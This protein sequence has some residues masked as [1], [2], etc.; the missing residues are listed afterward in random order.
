M[1]RHY[2]SYDYP[3]VYFISDKHAQALKKNEKLVLDYDRFKDEAW[4]HIGQKNVKLFLNKKIKKGDFNAYVYKTLLDIEGININAKKYRNT[5]S[6]SYKDNYYFHKRDEIN[7][8]IRKVY[9][10][11]K[12]A[13]ER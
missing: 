3:S 7:A 11:N 13:E 8:F 1:S 2:Y 6:F 12:T 10:H 5:R 4:W 9:E